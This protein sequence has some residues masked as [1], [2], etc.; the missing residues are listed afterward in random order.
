MALRRQA[1]LRRHPIPRITRRLH[2]H[3]H[4]IINRRRFSP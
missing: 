2:H 3:P 4:R 1:F